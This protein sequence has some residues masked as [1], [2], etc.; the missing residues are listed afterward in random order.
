MMRKISSFLFIVTLIM[1][2]VSC[3]TK[4][5]VKEKGELTRIDVQRLFPMETYGETVM[6]T[7]PESIEALKA[8]FENVRWNPNL[9]VK[10][11]RGPDVKAILFYRYDKNMPERL[12]EYRI[13]FDKE[14][15]TII[16]DVQEE[17]YG[18]LDKK[19]AEILKAEILSVFE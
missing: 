2:V 1:L 13:W 18:E 12:Y 7:K 9:E 19:H 5:I 6:I 16:S 11:S 15:A 8:I 10:L 4:D 3:Q 17:G 14:T